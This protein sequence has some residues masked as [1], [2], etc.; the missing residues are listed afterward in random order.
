VAKFGRLAFNYFEN[1][2]LFTDGFLVGN[3]FCSDLTYFDLLEFPN[4]DGIIFFLIR[5]LLF[6]LSFSFYYMFWSD[7][8]IWIYFDTELTLTR[9]SK[10]WS[11]DSLLD[12]SY[13]LIL[14]FLTIGC[15]LFELIYPWILD[16][17]FL[18]H[19]WSSCNNSF[20]IFF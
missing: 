3:I 6:N 8:E 18:N 20:L 13:D 17:L 5:I 9:L 12:N 2:S 4:D 1:G 16:F 19:R 15:W 14:I 7:F 10:F 11:F